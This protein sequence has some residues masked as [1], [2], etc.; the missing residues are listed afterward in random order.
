MHDL[1]HTVGT[2]AGQTGAN[3]FLIR[4]KLGHRTTAMTGQYINYSHD[5]VRQ[6]SDRVEGHI[7]AAM[8][9]RRSVK[10]VPLDKKWK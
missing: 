9:G 5:P 2:Y 3:A 6:L 8:K 1:R 4:D 10:T 7:A